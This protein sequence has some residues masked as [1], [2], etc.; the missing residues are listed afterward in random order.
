MVSHSKDRSYFSSRGPQVNINHPAVVNANCIV[1][2][3]VI[4]QLTASMDFFQYYHDH[5]YLYFN[6][7]VPKA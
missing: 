3:S 6:I 7:A 5:S 1:Q 4:L 2:N